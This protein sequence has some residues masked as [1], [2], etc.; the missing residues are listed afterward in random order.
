MPNP[1]IIGRIFLS[2]ICSLHKTF[3]GHTCGSD[4]RLPQTLAAAPPTLTGN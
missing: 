3:N 1:A 2:G 4:R